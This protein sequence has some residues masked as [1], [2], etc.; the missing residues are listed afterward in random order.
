VLEQ[1][2]FVEI[3]QIGS[4]V[5]LSRREARVPVP[6]HSSVAPGTLKNILRQAQITVDEF[7]SRLG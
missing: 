1:F 4:N 6:L 2:G 7:V 3:R 5:R